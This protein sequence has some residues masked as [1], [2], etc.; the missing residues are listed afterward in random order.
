LKT[1]EKRLP[2]NQTILEGE[3]TIYRR[4][5]KFDQALAIQKRLLSMNP[6]HA[7]TANDIGFTYTRLRK[8]AEAE[9][10][11]KQAISLEPGEYT[12]Y[13]NYAM[14]RF[15]WKGDIKGA[16]EIV[17]R[18]PVQHEPPVIMVK[19][20][21]ALAQRDY[22]AALR[23]LSDPK[24]DPLYL[25]LNKGIAYRYMN[26]PVQARTWFQKARDEYE[27][28]VQKTPGDP[29]LHALLGLAYAGLGQRE[30]AIREGKRAVELLP[31]SADASWGP[32]MLQHLAF[33]YTLVG[34]EDQAIDVI[35]QLLS[36]SSDL[37]PAILRIEP[38]W[39]PLRHNPRFQKLVQGKAES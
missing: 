17:D 25:A 30:P 33:T 7:P 15:R 34:E 12:G 19:F 1:A 22:S 28:N 5:G 13:M 31:V 16:Q 35:E 21:L 37:T 11:Y 32:F 27:S 14:T 26:E 6:R 39:D 38:R 36:I 2:N 23:V 3:A 24:T 20:I 8:Y 10:F 4:Q 9:H 18:C 29:E